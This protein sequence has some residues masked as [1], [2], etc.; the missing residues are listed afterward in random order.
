MK[1]NIKTKVFNDYMDNVINE[2]N[3]FIKDKE[4]IDIKQSVVVSVTA[5]FFSQYLVIYRE[6]DVD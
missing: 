1:I 4:V 2:M 5:Y 3:E 6:R